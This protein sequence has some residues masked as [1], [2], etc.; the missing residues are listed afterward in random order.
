MLGVSIFLAQAGAGPQDGFSGYKA[1]ASGTPGLF[2][3]DSCYQDE[4]GHGHKLESES[5]GPTS[6]NDVAN[7]L[8]G[9]L[10]QPFDLVG[11]HATATAR[12]QYQRRR[13]IDH[14]RP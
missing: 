8:A 9:L 1:F 5:A 14:H 12:A 13:P 11:R 4:H 10:E 7:R 2:N 3:N 6:A